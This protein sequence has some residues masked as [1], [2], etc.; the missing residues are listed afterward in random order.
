MQHAKINSLIQ[1]WHGESLP[2][3]YIYPPEDKRPEEFY[4]QLRLYFRTWFV[5]PVKRRIAKYY[6]WILQTFF[7]L[8]VIAITGSSG[9]TSTKD[10][11]NSILSTK[12]ETV[13]S[14]LNIDST[15]NI[16]STILRSKPTTH[17]L[18]LEMGVE[19]KGDMKFYRWLATPDLVVVSNIYQTHT[20]YFG[21]EEGVV[22]EK[23]GIVEDL[24][25][26]ALVVLNKENIHTVKMANKTQAKIVW[27]GK[28]G[29][30]QAENLKLSFEGTEFT[31]NVDGNKTQVKI[32]LIGKHFVSNAMAA[33]TAAYSLGVS[34]EKIK[35]GLEKALPPSQRLSV[36]TLK[37]GAIVLDDTYNNNPSAAKATFAAVKELREDKK[38]IL[39]YGDM[40]E[41]GETEVQRH[42]DIGKVIEDLKADFVILVG[43]LSVH[44]QSSLKKTK[45]V[46]VETA[47]E[48]LSVLKPL[49][50]K[51]SLILVK[52]AR[53]LKLEELVAK[54]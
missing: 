23:E 36:K 5:H 2:S 21:D 4:K 45:N 11:L 49:I 13:S 20:L 46:R 50:T 31:L 40:K 15:F 33:A 27:F 18:I 48:V 43:P 9:K 19:Y 42:K 14:H 3:I 26:L 54:L 22:Q 41:L 47:Q 39:V 28:G 17:Y 52:G 35:E 37:N 25:K 8:K 6:L 44:T 16:P 7:G 1:C 34:L 29:E 30:V 32:P 10:M 38:L 24:P 12:G 53:S 51:S